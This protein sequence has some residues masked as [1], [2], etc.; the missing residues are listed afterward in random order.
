MP[1]RCVNPS[2]SALDLDLGITCE[3]FQWTGVVVS[4]YVTHL[5]S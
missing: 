3:S 5:V 2:K 1:A 4:S